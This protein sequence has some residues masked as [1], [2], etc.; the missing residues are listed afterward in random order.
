MKNNFCLSS[1]FRFLIFSGCQSAHNHS[2]LA[3]DDKES[4]ILS[5]VVLSSE[6][7]LLFEFPTETNFNNK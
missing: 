6:Y 4:T 2:Q 7:Y 1:S 5:T 3:G